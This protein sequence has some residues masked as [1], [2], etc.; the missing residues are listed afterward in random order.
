MKLTSKKGFTLIELMI[1]VAIIGILAA[2]AIPNFIK[3]QARS[4]TG[5]AKQNLKAFYTAQKAYYQ[6]H[7]KYCSDMTLIGFSPE[8]GNRYTY[9]FDSAGTPAY[10]VR[11][12]S[13]IDSTTRYTG[14]QTDTFKHTGSEL[15]YVVSTGSVTF[16]AQDDGHTAI[17]SANAGAMVAMSTTNTD[18][19]TPAG[20]FVGFA[21]GNIDNDTAGIDG[22]FVSSQSGQI[23]GNASCPNVAKADVK[24][25]SAGQPGN[26]YNDVDCDG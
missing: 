16:A 3:F 18:C 1:V 10:Q 15:E 24:N 6:E 23:D 9:D 26:I 5:E 2:I 20:D 8:R 7:D 19:T 17:P 21:F 22:W 25:V 11:S 12:A 13:T 4:K 14:V